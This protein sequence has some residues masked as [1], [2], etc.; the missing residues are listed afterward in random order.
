MP[1]E[2][3]SS[4]FSRCRFA[5]RYRHQ[6]SASHPVIEPLPHHAVGEQA[7][8][9]NNETQSVVKEHQPPSSSEQT[10]AKAGTGVICRNLSL[11]P[12]NRP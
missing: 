2:G 1:L 4:L 11:P 8:Q 5:V 9:P 12:L 7:R 3:A 6:A 10:I